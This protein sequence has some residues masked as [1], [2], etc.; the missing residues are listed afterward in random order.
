MLLTKISTYTLTI[1]I[2]VQVMEIKALIT[3]NENM[4]GDIIKLKFAKANV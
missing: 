4:F 1:K 3:G 2:Y